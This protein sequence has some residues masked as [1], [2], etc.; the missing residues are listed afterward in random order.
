MLFYGVPGEKLPAALRAAKRIHGVMHSRPLLRLIAIAC[1]LVAGAGAAAL[2]VLIVGLGLGVVDKTGASEPTVA[3]SV[4]VMWL[5][6]FGIQHSGMARRR[7]KA[8]W[9]TS[10]PPG[11]ERS[12]YAAASGAVLLGLVYFWQTVPGEPWWSLPPWVEAGAALGA[13][14]MTLVLWR[15]DGLN[16]IGLR[17]PGVDRFLIV[18]PYRWVRHPLMTCLLLFLWGHARMPPTLALLSGGLTVYIALAIFL[19]ERDLA[20]RF[21]NAYRHYRRAVPAVLPW[22]WPAPAQIHDEAIR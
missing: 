11:L 14:G 12:C 15:F 7:F 22:R 20:V 1:A 16:L 13:V 4:N 3:V 5:V 17:P 18:G 21:G 6:L 10:A 19:E 8:L 9:P 2:C